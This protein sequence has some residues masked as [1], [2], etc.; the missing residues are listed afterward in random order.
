MGG[1]T[2]DPVK[3]LCSSVGKCQGQE[4]GVGELVNMGRG[5]EIAGFQRGNQERG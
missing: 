1:E 2:L 5:K 4:A 3:V